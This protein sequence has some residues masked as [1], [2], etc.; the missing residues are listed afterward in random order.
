[1]RI[2]YR[3][4]FEVAYDKPFTFPKIIPD[5]QR[6]AVKGLFKFD[7]AKMQQLVPCLQKETQRVLQQ[8][9]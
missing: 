1:M 3:H 6:I 8:T 5:N 4:L 9:E 2:W 7:G